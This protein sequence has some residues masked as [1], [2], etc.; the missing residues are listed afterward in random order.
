MQARLAGHLPLVMW[1]KLT[2]HFLLFSEVLC[3]AVK[4]IRL[5]SDS[6]KTEYALHGEGATLTCDYVIEGE[7][8]KVTSVRWNKN[9]RDVYV[10]KWNQPPTAYGVFEGR[11]DLNNNSPGTIYITKVHMEMEGEYTCKVQ[12]NIKSAEYDFYFTVI[13]DSCKENDWETHT[14][15]IT[16]TERVSMKCRGMFPKPSP[17]CGIYNELTGSYLISLTFDRVMVSDNG[18]YDITFSKWFNVRDWLNYT[19][20][21]FRCYVIVLGTKWRNGIRHKLFGDPGCLSYPPVIENGYFNISEE[22]SCWGMPREG[23]T[24][25]YHCLNG[26]N[27]IG[28]PVLKCRNGT[29]S[30]ETTASEW[31]KPQCSNGGASFPTSNVLTVVFAVIILVLLT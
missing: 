26:F 31:K 9:G 28:N 1:S 11:V 23:A 21:S 8:E 2:I 14:D 29:W 16:C 22:T 3:V 25:T 13:V 17:A 7:A 5:L 10:W 12:T 20:I 4:D 24:T 30:T 19:D 6:N 18:T 27:L 15:M